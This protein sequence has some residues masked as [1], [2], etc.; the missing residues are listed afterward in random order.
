MTDG[1]HKNA[2]KDIAK[3]QEVPVEVSSS[4]LAGTSDDESV[5]LLKRELQEKITSLTQANRQL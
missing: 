2:G 4:S 3:A 1:A 5:S